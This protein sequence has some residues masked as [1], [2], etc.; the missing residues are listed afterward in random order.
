MAETV[1]CHYRVAPGNEERSEVLLADHWPT[2]RRLG[3]VT[4][5]PPQHF[6]GLEQDNGQP[7]LE[8]PHV[9]VFRA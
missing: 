1:I 8:F 5:T 4:G 2:L 9:S 7:I 3:P 6:H